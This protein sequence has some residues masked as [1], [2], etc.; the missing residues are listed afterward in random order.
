MR[1]AEIAVDLARPF[2]WATREGSRVRT[3]TLELP[4]GPQDAPAV[5]AA[6][7]EA[8]R[9]RA[10]AAL[11]VALPLP[12][13][14]L[15][16]LSRPEAA[17]PKHLRE[18][19]RLQVSARGQG[20]AEVV[21][22][23]TETPT[24][25]VAAGCPAATSGA[26]AASAQ[27]AGF[28][29]EAIE[30]AP[31][32]LLRALTHSGSAPVLALHLYETDAVL[33]IGSGEE[34]FVARQLPWAAADADALALEVEQTVAS[35]ERETSPRIERIL[36]GG[37]PEYQRAVIPALAATLAAPVTPAEVHPGW[38]LPNADPVALLALGALLEP[39]G[40]S[41]AA[42]SR[43]RQLGPAWLRRRRAS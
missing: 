19:A 38:G 25:I 27:G 28:A 22:D 23:Y 34:F 7:R 3:G 12:Q 24:A 1:P 39:A 16:R 32:A 43:V 13:C 36:V 29:L 35:H 15:R 9:P 4:G 2:A 14:T 40:S 31:L 30:P 42:P 37:R 11:A 8:V 5:F 6:L 20:G 33:A 26:I 21:A 41:A 17:E 10:H 18:F